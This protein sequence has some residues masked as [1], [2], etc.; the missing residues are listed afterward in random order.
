MVIVVVEIKEELVRVEKLTTEVVK[1]GL[2]TNL[3]IQSEK[4]HSRAR[5]K[6]SGT[7]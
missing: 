3:V 1:V 5:L 2:Y 6:N 4:R 7:S